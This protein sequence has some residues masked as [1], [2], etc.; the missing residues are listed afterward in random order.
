MDTGR[1][2]LEATAP[3]RTQSPRTRRALA[4]PFPAEGVEDGDPG[5]ATDC[6]LAFERAGYR[7][8]A[9]N[10]LMEDWEV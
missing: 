7:W 8:L 10:G 3:W 1:G 5:D 9:A 2:M 4:P 6:D